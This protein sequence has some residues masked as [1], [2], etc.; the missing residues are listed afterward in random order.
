LPRQAAV[1]SVTPYPL[2]APDVVAFATIP[3]RCRLPGKRCRFEEPTSPLIVET[4]LR[5]ASLVPSLVRV[6]M[7]TIYHRILQASSKYDSHL[8]REGNGS[9][10]EGGQAAPRRRGAEDR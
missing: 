4:G 2:V 8:G 7:N 9:I 3:K 6:I 10:D 5:F 1:S